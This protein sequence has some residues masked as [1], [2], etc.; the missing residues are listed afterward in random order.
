MQDDDVRLKAAYLRA[1]GAIAF[2]TF[3][4]MLGLAAVAHP[5]VV[6]VLGEKWLPAVPLIH[7][8]APLGALQS[9]W[10]PIGIIFLV[11]DRTDW[12]FRLGVAQ[13]CLTVGA[14]LAGIPW[15]TLGVA[16][17]YALINLLWIPVWLWLGSS[18]IT[19]L[20]A[21]DFVKELLPYGLLSSAM[22]L[23]VLLCRQML[24]AAGA[25]PPLALGVCVAVGVG[26]YVGS[27]LVI[28]P[29]AL[30]DFARILPRGPRGWI[31]KFL[32]RGASAPDD[33]GML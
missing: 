29:A 7:V 10:I 18:L 5:F 4:M 24:I 33:T 9:V 15:G 11:K 17:A 27:V 13:G 20:R 2:V 25:A 31:M 3:P 19:G 12:Y 28:G 8:L 22:C 21:K 14:F 23:V 6:V 16:V 1:C 32:R 26:V 30:A